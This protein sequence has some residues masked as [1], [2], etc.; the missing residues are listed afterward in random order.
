[1]DTYL[2]MFFHLG[3]LTTCHSGW[4][5]IVQ[6]EDGVGIPEQI[7]D[8]SSFQSYARFYFMFTKCDLIWTLSYF[9]LIVL[10][11]LEVC[12]KLFLNSKFL[13]IIFEAFRLKKMKIE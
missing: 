11:F 10:N 8:S 12:S 3:K 5:C 1:M 7:L 2:C 4:K 9:A 13:L 6:A